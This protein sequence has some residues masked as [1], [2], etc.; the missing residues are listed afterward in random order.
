MP[1]KFFDFFEGE[2]KC[3]GTAYVKENGVAMAFQ[4]NTDQGSVRVNHENVQ[5]MATWVAQ[6]LADK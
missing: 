3:K 6:F 4:M 1:N 2:S 5:R